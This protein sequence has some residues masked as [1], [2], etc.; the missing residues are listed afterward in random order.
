M[1]QKTEVGTKPQCPGK[2][3]VEWQQA[4][5]RQGLAKG[6]LLP[7]RFSPWDR[8][9]GWLYIYIYIGMMIIGRLINKAPHVKMELGPA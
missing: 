5:W 1:F 7:K 2:V 4:A 8:I 3:E 9:F 6:L